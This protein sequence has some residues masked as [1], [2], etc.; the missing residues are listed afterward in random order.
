MLRSQGTGEGKGEGEGGYVELSCC[1]RE[2][3]CGL[4][5]LRAFEVTGIGMGYSTDGPVG[6]I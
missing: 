5:C 2:S 6:D 3:D 1:V 4:A